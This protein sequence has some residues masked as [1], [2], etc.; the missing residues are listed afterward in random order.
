MVRVAV[1]HHAPFRALLAAAY[2]DQFAAS[3]M[4]VLLGFQVYALTRNPF[5]LGLLGLLDHARS[6]RF[7][8]PARASAAETGPRAH[9]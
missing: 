6:G 3:A 1:L 5:A 4:T 8:D 9:G 7:H 2:L